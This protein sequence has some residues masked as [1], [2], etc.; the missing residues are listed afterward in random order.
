MHLF[1]CSQQIFIY[2]EY[3]DNTYQE[4]S[5]QYL[6]ADDVNIR[7]YPSTASSIIANLPIAT[8]L[9]IIEMSTERYTYNNISFPWYKVSFIVNHRE[10][11]GY[12]VGG[13]YC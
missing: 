4:G 10:K 8:R 11:I 6:I 13:F 1:G 9:R 3:N 5:F 7:N 2:D 12:V